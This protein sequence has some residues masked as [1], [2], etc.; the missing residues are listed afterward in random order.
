MHA[1][2]G[3]HLVALG[4]DHANV[5]GICVG[6]INLVPG[7]IDGDSGRSFANVDGG[8]NPQRAQVN[9][10]HRIT[11]AIGHVGKF[12]IVGTRPWRILAA[13]QK[14]QHHQYRCQPQESQE[15]QFILLPLP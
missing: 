10:C 4:I 2:G 12:T 9:G 8:R 1:N 13:A 11:T 14:R 6:D 5:V 15:W 7:G 3:N